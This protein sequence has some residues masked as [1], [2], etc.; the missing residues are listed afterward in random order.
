MKR[1]GCSNLKQL[2]DDD[3]LI[4][5]DLDTISELSTFIVKGQSF[6]ADEGCNDDLV[7]CLFLFA[8][9]TDQQYFKELSDLDVRATMLREQQDLLEQDMAPFGFIVDGL[10]DENIGEMV[11]EYGTRWNPVV[12]DYGSNW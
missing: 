11:D 9:A 10:E 5:E 12:R 1:I 4:I 2:V 8:W 3:K 6:E 7:S